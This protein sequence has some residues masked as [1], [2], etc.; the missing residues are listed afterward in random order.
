MDKT[1]GQLVKEALSKTTLEAYKSWKGAPDE[2]LASLEKGLEYNRQAIGIL[3]IMYQEKKTG[4]LEII[5]NP[6]ALTQV[7]KR[8]ASNLLKILEEEEKSI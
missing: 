4:V 3:H 5:V 8:L 2:E 1:P 7:T 6:E